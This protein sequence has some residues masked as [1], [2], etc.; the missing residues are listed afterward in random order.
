MTSF[1][2]AGFNVVTLFKHKGHE[3][4]EEQTYEIKVLF[5]LCVFGVLRV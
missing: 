5:P 2:S 3:D 1:S 4:L